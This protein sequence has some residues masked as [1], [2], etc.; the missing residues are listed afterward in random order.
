MKSTIFVYIIQTILI[1]NI[2]V[3]VLSDSSEEPRIF[4]IK[5]F[6]FIVLGNISFIVLIICACCNI[7]RYGILKI[8]IS[9]IHS[10]LKKRNGDGIPLPRKGK[11]IF[12]VPRQFQTANLLIYSRYGILKFEWN[13]NPLRPHLRGQ[14]V[15]E[16]PV[17]RIC[18]TAEF[19]LIAFQHF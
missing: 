1:G 10:V 16:R 6:I 9:P 18:D 4:L 14:G 19:F 2:F 17:L 5:I 7:C 11:N 8:F 3:N 15:V 13:Q 12:P